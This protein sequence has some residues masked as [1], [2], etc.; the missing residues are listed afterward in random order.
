MSALQGL[1]RGCSK[2]DSTPFKKAAGDWKATYPNVKSIKTDGRIIA[3]LMRN[4]GADKAT[5]RLG[6]N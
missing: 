1:A 3:P 4:M 5:S 6:G 2:P